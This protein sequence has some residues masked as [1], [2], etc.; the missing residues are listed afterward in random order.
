MPFPP[1]ILGME[2]NPFVFFAGKSREHSAVAPPS[3]QVSILETGE[4]LSYFEVLSMC[5]AAWLYRL[6]DS[7]DTLLLT[8]PSQ[9]NHRSLGQGERE[10]GVKYPMESVGHNLQAEHPPVQS[11]PRQPLP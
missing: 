3:L 10:E 4:R 11:L 8:R 7:P 1:D 2:R 6:P 9:Y 5:V